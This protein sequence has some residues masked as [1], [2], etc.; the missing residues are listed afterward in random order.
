MSPLGCDLRSAVQRRQP[1]SFL[2]PQQARLPLVFRRA[3][4]RR[5]ASLPASRRCQPR[6][7]RG[8]GSCYS[9]NAVCAGLVG[10]AS[11]S[12]GCRYRQ[13]SHSAIPTGCGDTFNSHT[14]TQ[15]SRHG[16]HALLAHWRMK[17]RR[18][19]KACGMET[20]RADVRRGCLR[21]R[22]RGSGMQS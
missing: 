17:R 9:N 13:T 6:R 5:E 18:D 19:A 21:P 14:H 11:K 20:T 7:R 3:D 15:A 10:E 2:G 12:S 16:G 4:E 1:R 8:G 22:L